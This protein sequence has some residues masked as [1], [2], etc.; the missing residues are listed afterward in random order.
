MPWRTPISPFSSSIAERKPGKDHASWPGSQARCR[1]TVSPVFRWRDIGFASLQ[2]FSGWAKAFRSCPR[3]FN[4]S[5]PDSRDDARFSVWA[6]CA[7]PTLPLTPSQAVSTLKSFHQSRDAQS[8]PV[9][10][11]GSMP[12]K[13]HRSPATGAGRRGGMMLLQLRWLVAGGRDHERLFV[14]A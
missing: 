3:G 9:F 14:P 6:R 11:V 2:R 7:L 5:Q 10:A 1:K 12:N 4:D 13:P 8:D